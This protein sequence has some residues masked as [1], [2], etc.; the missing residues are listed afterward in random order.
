M[1]VFAS[2]LFAALVIPAFVYGSKWEDGFEEG[3][4]NGWSDGWDESK[5]RSYSPPSRGNF[6]QGMDAW[7]TGYDAGKFAGY[8]AGREAGIDYFGQPGQPF[9]L[10]FFFGKK[11]TDRKKISLWKF[12]NPK[13]ELFTKDIFLF[14]DFNVTV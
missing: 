7:K 5:S 4:K 14:E 12:L 1:K 2:L 10:E 8:R 13:T 11:W 6:A 3:W 9:E